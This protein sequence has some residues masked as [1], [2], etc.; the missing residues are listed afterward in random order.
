MNKRITDSSYINKYTQ[1]K[2]I[3]TE[4]IPSSFLRSRELNEFPD[5]SDVQIFTMICIHYRSG[6]VRRERKASTNI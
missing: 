2:R 4:H 6:N 1:K 5:I 3:K